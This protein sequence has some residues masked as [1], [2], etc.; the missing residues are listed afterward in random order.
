MQNQNDENIIISILKRVLE[1]VTRK[2]R[3]GAHHIL[4]CSKTLFSVEA[5]YEKKTIT[6]QSA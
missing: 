3:K 2:G 4:A 5:H 6:I 1:P